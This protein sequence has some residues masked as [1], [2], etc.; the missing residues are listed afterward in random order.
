LMTLMDPTKSA[1]LRPLLAY[2]NWS[3]GGLM[4]PRVIR[5]A[6][7]STMKEA[8]DAVRTSRLSDRPVDVF[9]VDP[10]GRLVG[11][12][13]LVALIAASPVAVVED[14]MLPH[15]KRL[16]A[17][18][19]AED[20]LRLFVHYRLL[21]APVVDDEQTLI[22]VI[23]LTDLIDSLSPRSWH[24]RPRRREGQPK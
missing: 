2:P 14:V 3:A 12:L 6:Q 11:Q 19:R 8:L 9:V 4:S 17:S 22:G 1:E 5:V 16:Q 7:G 23:S 24:D 15:P 10:S 13:S 18:D 20:A 21:F